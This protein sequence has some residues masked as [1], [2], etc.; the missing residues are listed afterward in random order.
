MRKAQKETSQTTFMGEFTI[1]KMTY[2]QHTQ[3]SSNY[4]KILSPVSFSSQPK[5][6]LNIF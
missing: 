1:G 4:P 2:V 6:E 5:M 3:L